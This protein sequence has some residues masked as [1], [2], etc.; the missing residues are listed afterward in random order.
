MDQNSIFRNGEGDAWY[1]RNQAH[2]DNSQA[3]QSNDVRYICDTLMPFKERIWNVLEVGC[4]SGIK[5]EVIC[6]ELSAKGNGIEPSEQAVIDGNKRIKNCD[7]EL[8]HGS[9]ERLPFAE[10]SFDLVCFAF[11]LYL[12]DRNSLMQSLAEVDRV[13]KPGGFLAI[14]DFDPGS[15]RKRSYSHFSGVYSYKQNY[16]SFYT[17]TGLYDLV[18]KHSFSHRSDFFDQIADE[19]VST[20]ILYKET[21][22]FL[23][24][25]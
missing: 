13:L 16:A 14:T 8:V 15:P 7:I 24:Q 18:G 5:L 20:Q 2:L 17:Q 3:A 12:F 4:S 25:G 23:T 11:C 6:N 19:R 10:N 1:R 21:D 22:P 9:G